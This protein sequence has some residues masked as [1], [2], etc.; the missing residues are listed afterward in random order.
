MRSGKY[1]ES[2][3]GSTG[4]EIIPDNKAILFL[5]IK[6]KVVHNIDRIGILV[7]GNNKYNSH[8]AL[9]FQ[10]IFDERFSFLIEVLISGG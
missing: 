8:L 9:L 10:L 5:E 4:L 6:Q 3:E 2:R 7:A 1:L